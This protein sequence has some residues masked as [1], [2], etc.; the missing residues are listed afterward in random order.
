MLIVKSLV[1]KMI[2]MFIFGGAGCIL[3]KRGK[4]TLEGNAALCNLLV[5]FALPCMLLD[6]FIIERTAE[7]DSALLLSAVGSFAILLASIAIALLTC[8]GDIVAQNAVIFTNCGF[9]GIP[10]VAAIMDDSCLVY[11]AVFSAAM[12]ML[13]WSYGA[14]LFTE[15]KGMIRPLAQLK[16]PVMISVM[17]GVAL[18]LTGIRPPELI[19]S[20]VEVGS[21][22]CM[23]ISMLIVGVYASMVDWRA[24]LKKGHVFVVSLI[25]MLLAPAAAVA[26]ISLLPGGQSIKL[27]LLIAAACPTATN[28]CTSAQLFNGDY[29]YS[30]EI[31][32]TNTIMALFTMPAFVYIGMLLWK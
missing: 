3:C 18:Y 12:N 13:Q 30:V 11:M 17:L 29:T 7:T 16:K 25:R 10:L 1:S 9:F 2:V 27:T 28:V 32:V 23:P 6:S 5:L 15:D 4:I 21:S 14:Y 8:R 22:L 24:V 31:V 20:A 26:L 19:L